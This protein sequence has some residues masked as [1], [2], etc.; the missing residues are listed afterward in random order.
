[1]REY[2]VIEA[3][4]ATTSRHGRQ[5]SGEGRWAAAMDRTGIRIASRIEEIAVVASQVEAFGRDNGLPQSAVNDLNVA[6]DEVINNVISYGYTDTADH[7]I[8]VALSYDGK[9]LTAVVTDDGMPFDPLQAP[10][11]KL[12]AGLKT[13]RIG[14]LG[15]HFVRNL[16]DQCIYSRSNG[17][18]ELTLRKRVA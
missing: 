16:M 1:M 10:A 7:T 3:E 14:G 11:P 8:E 6:L 4:H 12:G 17:R 2:C 13:R 5:L 9:D 15:I 18:N